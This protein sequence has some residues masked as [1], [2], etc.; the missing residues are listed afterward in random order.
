[1]TKINRKRNFFIQFQ[2][3]ILGTLWLLVGIAYFMISEND[4]F[5]ILSG[6]NLLLGLFYFG[7]HFFQK[8]QNQEF[9]A[10]DEEQLTISKW[11]QKPVTYPLAEVS[12][13]FITGS[14]FIVKTSPE[15]PGETMEL[16][17]YSESDLDLLKSRFSPG[18]VISA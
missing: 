2:N 17:G 9:I 6:L 7:L 12:Q 4:N 16:S 1:M 3:L 14:Y 10:W 13:I 5:K 8:G 15:A 11:Q 18:K